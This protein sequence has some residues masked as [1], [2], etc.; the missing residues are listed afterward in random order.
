[1]TPSNCLV[2]EA[3]GSTQVRNLSFTGPSPKLVQ[4][5]LHHHNLFPENCVFNIILSSILIFKAATF[6]ISLPNS[7]CISQNYYP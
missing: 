6:K 1:M 2:L 7:T 3:E 4:Y 5:S